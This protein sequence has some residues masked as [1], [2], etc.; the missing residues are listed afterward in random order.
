MIARTRYYFTQTTLLIGHFRHGSSIRS[1]REQHTDNNYQMRQTLSTNLNILDST[2]EIKRVIDAAEGKRDETFDE[3]AE[4]WNE[5]WESSRT[6][7]MMPE[8]SSQK[9]V[10]GSA[11]NQNYDVEFSDTEQEYI[12]NLKTVK[13]GYLR[14]MAPFQYYERGSFHGVLK[15]IKETNT[16]MESLDAIENLKADFT[17]SDYYSV[18]YYTERRHFSAFAGSAVFL[19][20]SRS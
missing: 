15:D 20:I 3:I 1:L 9:T 8:G 14:N 11:L 7:D 10:L 12:D 2:D 16:I 17:V 13:V 4:D 18:Y 5:R 6:D 19:H